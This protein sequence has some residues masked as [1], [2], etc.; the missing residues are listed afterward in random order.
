VTDK[1]QLQFERHL[2]EET[3]REAIDTIPDGFAIYDAQDRLYTFNSAYAEIYSAS[4]AAL[5]IGTNFREIIKF[6]LENGQY[7]QAGKTFEEQQTWMKDRLEAHLDPEPKTIIQQTS[8]GR[9]LKITERRT[10]SGLT[11][12]I[13]TDI[14]DIKATEAEL[15]EKQNLLE[16]QASELRGLAKE[17]LQAKVHAE[18]ATQAKSEF[19][20]IISHELRT[21]MTGILGLT[22]IM[23]ASDPTEDQ[24]SHLGQL[25]L[26]ANSLLELLNDILD[27]SKFEAGKLELEKTEFDVIQIGEAVVKLLGPVAASKSIEL[28]STINILEDERVFLGDGNRIR[29]ILL[30]LA[31]NAVKFTKTGHVKILIEPETVFENYVD[32]LFKVSDTGIGISDQQI[33]SLFEPFSQADSSTTRKFGGTGLGLSICKKL[34]S[35]MGGVIS[36]ESELEKGSEFSFVLRL[37]HGDPTKLVNQTEKARNLLNR[38]ATGS[39]PGLSILLAEDVDINRMIVSTVLKKWGHTVEEVVNGKEAVDKAS[40]DEQFDLI[41]MDMQMPEM[42]GCD[43]AIAIRQLKGANSNTPII[44]LTADIQAAQNERYTQAGLDAFLHKPV[45]WDMLEETILKFSA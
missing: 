25:K 17:Y 44:A 35:A 11:V 5:K 34:V 1:R 38:N 4:A 22:D 20:A 28:H 14:T 45:D 9:W 3:L 24:Q 39:A 18:E 43:A 36:V 21:P 41:L 37:T 30:N 23:L 2:A 10:P 15:R 33:S 31:S 8:G 12:G 19:L 16:V 13:R 29:Q 40:G 6:G 42:D 26:S 7:P 32:I 27:Y